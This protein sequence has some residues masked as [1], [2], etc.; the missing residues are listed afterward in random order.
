MYTN[1]KNTE[2]ITIEKKQ[3]NENQ[4]KIQKTDS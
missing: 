3:N 1:K 4:R 2:L